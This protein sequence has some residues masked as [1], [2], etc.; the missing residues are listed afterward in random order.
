[1]KN[2]FLLAVIAAFSSC[3]SGTETKDDAMGTMSSDSTKKE[4]VVYAY[5]VQYTNFEMGDAKHAQSILN[6]WKAWDNNDLTSVKDSFSDSLELHLA[7]GSLIKGSRDSVL[8]TLQ[9]YR[10][11]FSSIKSSV[12]GVMSIKGLNKNTNQ[13]E[14]YVA[15]WGKEVSTTKNGKTDSLWLHEIWLI[16]KDG[17]TNY[18]TQ[19]SQV[20]PKPRIPNSK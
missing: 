14:N 4:D 15:V 18:A 1:M 7:D 6:I 2:V 20:I 17:K 9:L 5:P 10:N 11:N 8:S 16:D 3:N 12:D 13:N 19:Y